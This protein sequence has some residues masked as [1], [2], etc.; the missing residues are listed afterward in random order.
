MGFEVCGCNVKKTNGQDIV[1]IEKHRKGVDR[2]EAVMGKLVGKGLAEIGQ[3]T[4]LKLAT[5]I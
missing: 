1:V 4:A 5:T 2:G 3:H